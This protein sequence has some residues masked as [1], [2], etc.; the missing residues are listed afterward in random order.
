MVREKKRTMGL[1]SGQP[2]S[3]VGIFSLLY[4][5]GSVYLLGTLLFLPLH[6][7]FHRM[8]LH[9]VVRTESLPSSL[10]NVSE[11]NYGISLSKTELN[12]CSTR[13]MD[14]VLM[15]KKQIDGKIF[16]RNA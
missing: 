8:Y 9:S 1:F 3:E 7:R 11:G 10:L 16:T 12:I 15:E 14:L 5:F 4:N 13:K 2:A 6:L